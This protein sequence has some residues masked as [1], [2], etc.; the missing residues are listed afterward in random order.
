MVSFKRP[1]DWGTTP[2]Y[3]WAWSSSGNLFSSW[4]GIAMEDKGN[5]WFSYTLPES[6]T[7]VNII[8]SRNGNPQ[9]VDITAVTQTTCYEYDAPSGNKFTVKTVSCPATSVPQ[10]PVLSAVVYPQ[11][12][13]THF[14]V[15]LP[16]IDLSRPYQM[17][18]T[19]LS[20]RTVR[21]ET[22]TQQSNI[23]EREGLPAGIYMVR[24]V[25][26]NGEVFGSKLVLK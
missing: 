8:F 19:D 9:S 26:E 18:I 20:G 22:V 10:M 12:A 4:P 5:N 11:P 24:V 1:V 7:S 25:G 21:R 16:N 14:V 13:T 3:L 6:L 23:F 2:V 15:D 17:T